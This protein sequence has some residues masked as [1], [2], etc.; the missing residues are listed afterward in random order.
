[1]PLSRISAYL[2]AMVLASGC[3]ANLDYADFQGVKQVSADVYEVFR[4]DHK[5][6]FGSEGSL[7]AKVVA[8]ANAFAER[9]GMSAEPIEAKQHRVGI[10]GD[11]A[12][13][14]YKFRLVPKS[15]RSVSANVAEIDFV[16]D[17]RMSNNFL[18]TKDADSTPMKPSQDKDLY[19]EL[20]KLDELRKE[21][22]LT[23][24]EFQAQKA[25][26]LK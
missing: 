2:L 18:E 15:V 14:Y 8:E 19:E 21:G 4:E 23:E 17:A 26:L 6:V 16:G 3:A 7:Q 24:E 12:W 9:Q 22:I 25:K 11:W 5:G 20:K 10:L 1:M 13:A